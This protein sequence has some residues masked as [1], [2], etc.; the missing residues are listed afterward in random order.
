MLLAIFDERV[1]G[2]LNASSP[3]PAR[4]GEFAHAMGRAVGR[5]VWLRVPGLAMRLALGLV[6]DSILHNRRMI[7]HKALELGY[8][9]QFP[10]LHA[11]LADLIRNPG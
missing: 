4:F 3:E 7:P 8:L 6:A 10:T 1:H 11:A 9:F 2:G 5:R